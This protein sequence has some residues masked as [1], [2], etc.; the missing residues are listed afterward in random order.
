MRRTCASPAW[1]SSATFDPAWRRS[2]YLEPF[3]GRLPDAAPREVAALV[4]LALIALLLGVW[5]TPLLSSTAAGA[6]DV[7]ETV[8]P[9]TPAPRL[10]RRVL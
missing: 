7:T 4:P 10:P 6:R 5:P 8:E 9:P 2:T 3:G 1:F